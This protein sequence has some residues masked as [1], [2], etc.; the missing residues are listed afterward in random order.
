MNY[1]QT[2]LSR[3]KCI[4]T[5]HFIY[6]IQWQYDNSPKLWSFFVTKMAQILHTNVMFRLHIVAVSVKECYRKEEV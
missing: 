4:K 2:N 1:I 3:L 5:R 6:P